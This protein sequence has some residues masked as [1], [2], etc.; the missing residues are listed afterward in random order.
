[1]KCKKSTPCVFCSEGQTDKCIK[2]FLKLK[3]E[4]I[5]P[6]EAM[7]SQ[8]PVLVIHEEADAPDVPPVAPVVLTETDHPPEKKMEGVIE[9]ENT[10]VCC[11]NALR[12]VELEEELTLLRAAKEHNDAVALEHAEEL[13]EMQHE[14]E[15]QLDECAP[16]SALVAAVDKLYSW[17]DSQGEEPDFFTKV[18]DIVKLFSKMQSKL[19]KS[20]K[21]N[22]V[23]LKQIEQFESMCY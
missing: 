7:E 6:V 9:Q 1:M 19:E 15:D 14:L 4:D 5:Q 17:D 10:T 23:L 20:E 21:M 13:L 3:T 16:P 18:H 2:S 22:N 8:A 11:K 12:V